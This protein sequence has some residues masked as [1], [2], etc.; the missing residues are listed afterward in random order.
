MES[1]LCGY[2]GVG[3]KAELLTCA[4]PSPAGTGGDDKWRK[5]ASHFPDIYQAEKGNE[6]IP[7]ILV[8]ADHRD[9]VVAWG[10]VVTRSHSSTKLS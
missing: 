4:V 8:T 3:V 1:L 10:V 6:T 7:F 2:E 9:Q 5:A